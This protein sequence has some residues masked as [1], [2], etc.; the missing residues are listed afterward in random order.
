MNTGLLIL[1]VVIGA[2]LVGHGTQKLFGWF[3]GHGLTTTGGFFENLGFRP[4][5]PY[6]VAA[7]LTEAVGGLFL[8]LGLFTPLAAAAIIG[9]MLNAAVTVHG[10]KGVWL[11]TGGYEYTLVL[12][13]VASALAFTGAG[14][15]SL[16]NAFGLDLSGNFWGIAALALGL[17]S[18][19]VILSL[20][21]FDDEALEIADDDV[22][23]AAQVSA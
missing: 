20:R 17:V 21:R 16:D 3:G 8:V 15:V 14:T 9:T 5:R 6:A 19:G 1:R 18:G 22:P 11:T 13:T 2:L 23:E 10:D 4:G 12:G 7:G